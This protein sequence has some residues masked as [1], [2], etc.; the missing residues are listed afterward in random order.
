M[1][2][3]PRQRV[4]RLP[5]GPHQRAFSSTGT[6]SPVSSPRATET[7][8]SRGAGGRGRPHPQEPTTPPQEERRGGRV[9][10]HP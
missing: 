7:P 3:R 1:R 6:T 8:E 4:G 5:Q 9:G 2:D 10:G